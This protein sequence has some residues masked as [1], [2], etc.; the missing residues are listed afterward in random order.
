MPNPDETAAKLVSGVFEV[1]EGDSAYK[2]KVIAGCIDQLIG[3][4][5]HALVSSIAGMPAQLVETVSDGIIDALE[6]A[7]L[8]RLEAPLDPVPPPGQ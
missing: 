6:A 8:K 5:P 2:A 4:D 1:L 3:S 7:V